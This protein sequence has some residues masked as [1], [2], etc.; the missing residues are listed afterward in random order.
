[1]SSSNLSVLA[2]VVDIRTDSPLASDTLLLD[3]NVWYWLAYSRASQTNQPPHPYQT[4][5]YP[6]YVGK[7]RSAK[8]TLLYCGTTLSELIHQ[9]EKSER[10]MMLKVNL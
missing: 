6:S 2:D 1:M 3:T 5:T 8:G 10:E 4:S 9:I 7:A